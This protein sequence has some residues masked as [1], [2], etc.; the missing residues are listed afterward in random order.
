MIKHLV[1]AVGMLAALGCG[2]DAQDDLSEGSNE[3][4]EF[5][6][7]EPIDNGDGTVALP[8]S[9]HVEVPEVEE[10]PTTPAS[11]V[12][13]KAVDQRIAVGP[14][15]SS[16]NFD[17]TLTLP[18]GGGGSGTIVSMPYKWNLSYKPVG[19][20][21]FLCRNGTSNCITVTGAQT[22]TAFAFHGTASNVPFTYVFRVNGA[23]AL[24]P[25]AFGQSDEV[26]INY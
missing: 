17:F 14:N 12:I 4:S 8:E 15:V 25:T 22:G 24:S 6:D 21:V 19:L 26:L 16:K 5:S 18:Y 3:P 7:D 20:V 23:G 11:D 13:E 10:S 1:L 2:S 9:W